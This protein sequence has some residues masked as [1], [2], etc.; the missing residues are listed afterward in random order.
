MCNIHKS[1][2]KYDPNNYRGI[3][4]TS[5]LG[6]LFS[7]VLYKRIE[8]Q[9]EL[10]NI[11]VKEQAGFRKNHRTTDHIFV[12]RSLIKKVIKSGSYLYSCFVD[13]RKAYDSV[14]RKG[15]LYKLRKVGVVGKM[16]DIIRSMYSNPKSSVFLNGK[17]SKSFDTTIGVK[18]G[19]VLSTLLFNIFINDLPNIFT[20][21]NENPT[22]F[23][24][25]IS[26]LLF[27]DDLIIFA[28]T[29]DELQTKINKLE[30]YCKKWG[31]TVNT[32][33]TKIMIF[34]KQGALIKKHKFFLHGM[35]IE[36]VNQY[37][38][39]GFTLIPSG[40]AH[41]GIDNLINKGRKAWFAILK[42]LQKSKNK[43]TSTYLKLIDSLIKPIILYACE[44]WGGDESKDLLKTKIEKF[45]LSMCKQILGINK[46]S[47]N[48]N[49]LAELGR[50]PLQV[51]IEQ[52]IFKYFQRFIYI[53]KDRYLYKAFQEEIAID[54]GE[55]KSW[56]TMI[57][58]KLDSHGLTF[59]G[60]DILKACK[61]EELSK[62]YKNKVKIYGNRVKD[63]YLQGHLFTSNRSG[64]SCPYIA[65]TKSEYKSEKYLKLR[66]F[67]NRKAITKF[68]TSSNKLHIETGKWDKTNVLD[69]LCKQCDKKEVEDEI[70][71]LFNCPKYDELRTIY[72]RDIFTLENYKYVGENSVEQL[73]Y[74]FENASL[75]CLNKLGNFLRAASDSRETK[76]SVRKYVI[77]L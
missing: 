45:H 25:Q 38:Y 9:L 74:F 41:I 16:F 32:S 21:G 66:D 61:S 8:G 60:S 35:E 56:V 53:D 50:Y 4:L 1:G 27:A 33:K 44:C 23:N 67:E 49:C 43:S 11:L 12:I 57:K 73:Q 28:L 7:T 34:N 10:N 64:H 31:L 30:E 40:K 36:P 14:W 54:F 51:E 3:T 76:T 39:L 52:Q 65:R 46:S 37:S 55:G 24:T 72:F 77:I 20:G 71:F 29:K 63:T 5:C 59:L 13:F 18:Q 70:H 22:I 2:S 26:S 19:D 48:V 58:S 15:L 17:H 6:K 62:Q 68:R 75:H 47:N 69:R 42:N